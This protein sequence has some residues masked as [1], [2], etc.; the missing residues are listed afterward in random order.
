MLLYRIFFPMSTLRVFFT[1]KRGLKLPYGE[2]VLRGF[3]GTNG[4]AVAGN[5]AEFLEKCISLREI[6]LIHGANASVKITF[7]RGES[8]G[9]ALASHFDVTFAQSPKTAECFVRI[10]GKHH[11]SVFVAGEESVGNTH[12]L[13][14]PLCAFN[15]NAAFGIGNGQNYHVAAV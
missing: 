7:E 8:D 2:A 15:I 1:M 6:V 3:V 14:R 11:G 9:K 12:C 5:V 4:D 13:M 10:G